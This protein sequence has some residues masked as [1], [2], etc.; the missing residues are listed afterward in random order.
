M[1]RVEFIGASYVGKSTIYKELAKKLDSESQYLTEEQF[2][3]L[4]RSEMGLTVFIYRKVKQL[5]INNFGGFYNLYQTQEIE[6]IDDTTFKNY[7]QTLTMCF[8]DD[9]IKLKGL[10]FS[11][12]I[13]LSTLKKVAQYN[14]YQSLN[15]EKTILVEESIIHW[16]LAMHVLL[17]NNKFNLDEGSNKDIGL[18]PKAIIY[19]YADEETILKRIKLR[20]KD[21]KI[22]SNHI[23]LTRNEIL[24]KAIVKQNMFLE[25][26]KFA[27]DI[28][29]NVLRINT[30]DSIKEN[31]QKI[32]AF[33]KV[34]H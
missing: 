26:A 10:E 9:V 32:D 27:E 16:H 30:A 28:G 5:F 13:Y 34:I 20:E 24:N 4:G 7:E 31:I 11:N 6:Y 17:L 33:L 18:F 15:S 21:K 3:K 8:K 29:S 25:Y 22:N 2:L 19:C 1:K 12:K 23:N 14:Y